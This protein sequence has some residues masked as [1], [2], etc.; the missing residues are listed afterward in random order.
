[1]KIIFSKLDIDLSLIKFQ[2]VFK[3]FRNYGA[4]AA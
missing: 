2:A 3:E 4:I 1:M